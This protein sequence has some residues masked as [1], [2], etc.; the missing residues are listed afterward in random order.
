LPTGVPTGN[1]A[2]TWTRISQM[3]GLTCQ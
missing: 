2:K 1:G 3:N